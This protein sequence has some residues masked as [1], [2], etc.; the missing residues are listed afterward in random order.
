MS[1]DTNVAEPGSDRAPKPRLLIS[2][3]RSGCGIRRRLSRWRGHRSELHDCLQFQDHHPRRRPCGHHGN[4]PD[5]RD[6]VGQLLPTV[7]EGNRSACDHR[8]R[9]LHV[10]RLWVRD[11][12][13][14][15]RWPSRLPPALC[16]AC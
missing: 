8:V 5:L 1:A 3:D 4:R 2:C 16:R 14:D 12:V 6:A 9:D 10:G 7:D 15:A 11:L 13:S